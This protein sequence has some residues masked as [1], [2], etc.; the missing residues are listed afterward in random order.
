MTFPPNLVLPAPVTGAL[1]LYDQA[2]VLAGED[3]APAGQRVGRGAD[4]ALAAPVGH[5]AL[6]P[7][8]HAVHGERVEPG[9]RDLD[10]EDGP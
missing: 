5:P 9:L 3:D 10:H 6:A 7:A 4:D 1:R 8:G 2:T